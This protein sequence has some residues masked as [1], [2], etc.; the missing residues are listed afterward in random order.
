MKATFIVNLDID[1]GVIQLDAKRSKRSPEGVLAELL[2]DVNAVSLT[3]FAGEMAWRASVRNCS[4][5]R[6]RYGNE[7][8]EGVCRGKNSGLD[9]L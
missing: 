4:W 8:R 6:R 5:S 3:R 1:E 2:G 7:Q 9:L